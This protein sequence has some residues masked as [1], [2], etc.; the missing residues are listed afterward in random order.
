MMAK[1]ALRQGGNQFRISSL[2]FFSFEFLISFY[3]KFSSCFKLDTFVG[4]VSTIFLAT[5]ELLFFLI[6]IR[7]WKRKKGFVQSDYFELTNL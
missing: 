7:L 5:K 1:I 2:L 3:K 4:R 6:F